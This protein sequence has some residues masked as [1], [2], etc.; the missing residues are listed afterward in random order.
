VGAAHRFILNDFWLLLRNCIIRFFGKRCYTGVQSCQ[1][2]CCNRPNHFLQAFY[3]ILVLGPF[4][5][6]VWNA[7]PY[8][9][10]P[11]VPSYHRITLTAM[12]FYTLAHWLYT[13][14][15]DPGVITSKTI[16]QYLRVFPYDGILYSKKNCPTCG[17]VKPARSKHCRICNRCVARFDHHCGW[18]N[19]D[20]GHKNLK[21]FLLFLLNTGFLCLYGAY[22]TFQIVRGLIVINKLTE[23]TIKSK[24][25]IRI[26]LSYGQIFQF[27]MYYMT[28]VVAVGA[29]CFFTSLTLFVFFGYHVYLLSR[30]TTTNES[31]KWSDLR[32]Q[33]AQYESQKKGANLSNKQKLLVSTSKRQHGRQSSKSKQQREKEAENEKPREIT[34]KDLVNIYNKGFWQNLREVFQ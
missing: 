29:F 7:F 15:T 23:L 3:L 6:F 9:P 32:S 8:I 16:D 25:G 11:F 4:V 14:T 13:C 21:H 34:R 1:D 2:Y 10:G 30:N 31:F 17:I 33:V 12:V 20:V 28:P 18:I 22:L 24:E 26:H 5:I 27:V 19:N